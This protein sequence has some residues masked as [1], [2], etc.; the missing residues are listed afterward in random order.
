MQRHYDDMR[1]MF[2]RVPDSP[3]DYTVNA[4]DIIGNM[5]T[6]VFTAKFNFELTVLNKNG[7][8]VG[9]LP[10][11]AAVEECQ[12]KRLRDAVILGKADPITE[13]D[14]RVTFLSEATHFVTSNQGVYHVTLKVQ[15][16]YN[17]S[18]KQ[19]VTVTIPRSTR[20]TLEATIPIK[21]I[22]VSIPQSVSLEQKESD[23]KTVVTATVLPSTS[24]SIKWTKNAEQKKN[25][26]SGKIDVPVIKPKAVKEML[27]TS[28]QD[29]VHSIGGGICQTSLFQHFTIING[30]VAVFTFEIGIDHGTTIKSRDLTEKPVEVKDRIKTST[31]KARILSCDGSGIAKWD[32]LDHP[33][34]SRTQLLKVQMES[35][36][37]GQVHF[38][39]SAE[40]EMCGTSC[41]IQMPTITPIGTG[42]NKGN[43]AIQART[44]VEIQE[45]EVKRLSKVDILEMP[46]TL[47]NYAGIL[48]CYKFLTSQ[49]SLL[50]SVKKHD[51]VDVLV[52]T[53]EQAHYTVTH[54]GEHLFYHLAFK[55][56]NTQCQFARVTIPSGSTIWSA[57]VQGSAVK[58]SQDREGSTLL[59]LV[60]GSDKTFSAELL[61]VKP[62]PLS[63]SQ[64]AHTLKIE[65]P[66]LNIPVNHLYVTL[67]MPEKN[68]FSAWEGDLLEVQYWSS[69]P[70]ISEGEG[71]QKNVARHAPAQMWANCA[72]S[73]SS[74]LSDE[75]T[76][77]EDDDSY[78]AP[79][80]TNDVA[81]GIKPLTFKSTPLHT[82]RQF[83]LEKLLVTPNQK[84]SLSCETALTKERK[85]RTLQE[86]KKSQCYVQ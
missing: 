38:T 21:N 2:E 77:E 31:S 75:D 86:Q 70:S 49:T 55:V 9:L 16:P 66:T 26:S 32:V 52:A 36:A 24:L 84:L 44:A 53:A 43:I 81:A 33:E 42:R 57:L 10:P 79:V 28:G 60:K 39:I 56:R 19:A 74:S 7:A 40:L 1:K 50:L 63:D 8:Q 61:F 6:Q 76:D 51:D 80:N 34:K 11:G 4:V 23:A 3:I 14:G 65:L 25:I 29:Y 73:C 67:W 83:Q 85:P 37:E 72:D 22:T 27:I 59:P 45:V 47:V 82:G 17:T 46:Q 48:H 30:S 64:K 5:G 20:T 69:P 12:C 15:V 18:Q 35:S 54:T 41:L 13:E 62:S 71:G 78:I 58:P 68:S